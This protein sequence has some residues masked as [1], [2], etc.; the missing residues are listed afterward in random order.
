MTT[1]ETGLLSVMYT[2]AM[3]SDSRPRDRLIETTGRLLRQQGYSG[4]GLNQI[5][6]ES[7]APKGSL[8][9]YFP[10]GKEELVAAA[11][12]RS[13]DLTAAGMR[14]ELD[15]YDEPAEGLRAYIRGVARLL[16]RSDYLLGCP[17]TA[18][19]ADTAATSE[20][21][22]G[23]TSSIFGHWQEVMAERLIRAGWTTDE[24]QRC[25]TLALAA[26]EGAL[27]LGRAHRDTEPLMVVA[28]SI[29][30]LVRRR[31]PGP[32]D[33]TGAFPA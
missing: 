23:V 31:P 13:D 24:A 25:A 16:E 20:T 1:M 4:T 21:L 8:Y 3:P 5:L 26:L 28:D 14:R 30:D 10:G 22:R 9:F 27:L 15:A 19:T 33:G 11:L 29:A 17:V 6:A 2:G 32:A 7:G 12:Q 18:V